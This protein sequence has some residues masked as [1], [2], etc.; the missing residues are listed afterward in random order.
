MGALLTFIA[1]APQLM[2]RPEFAALQIIGVSAFALFASQAGRISARIGTH[3]AVQLGAGVQVL[4]CGLLLATGLAGDI[5]FALFAAFWFV[6]CGA[7]AV[8]GPAA[9]SDALDVPSSR[10]GR[11]SAVMVLAILAAGAVGTQ[12]VAP[13]LRG[14]SARGLLA[15]L[16]IACAMSVMLVIP[17]PRRPADTRGERE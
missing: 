7:L 4:T 12:L 10:L 2:S 8:R 16:V 1:S 15:A 13:F 11:A 5:T 9:F 17:Y 14:G 3:R 6:F